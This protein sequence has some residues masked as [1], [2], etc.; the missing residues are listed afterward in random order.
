MKKVFFNRVC[1]LSGQRCRIVLVFLIQFFL[2]GSHFSQVSAQG[3][4]F[5]RNFM[6]DDYHAHSR[7]FDIAIG[8]DGTVYVA[9]FEGLMYYDKV[10]WHMLHTPGITRV[11]VVYRDHNNVIWA[12]GYNYFG[13]IGKKENGELYLQR[14]G[15]QDLFQGEVLEIWEKGNLLHFIVNNGQEYAV[16]GKKIVTSKKVHKNLLKAGLSDIVD[17]ESVGKDNV[18]LLTNITQT[19]KLGSGLQAVVKKGQGL[20]M[21]DEAGK[22]LYVITKSNGLCNDNITYVAYDNHGTLWGVTDEGLFSLA[23]PSA[24]SRFGIN[25]GLE[26]EIISIESFQQSMYVGTNAGLF[27]QKGRA[28]E[29]VGGINHACWQLLKTSKGLLA[30][31]AN[32]IYLL[33]VGNVRQISSES[34]T[35]VLEIGNGKVY[36]GEMDGLKLVDIETG[37]S[38]KV[39]DLEKV[40]KI[41][42]DEKG[43]VWLE[44]LYGEVWRKSPSDDKFKAYRIGI[45]EESA[46]TLVPIGGNV[47]A[48]KV[49]AESPF[50]YPRFSYKDDAG[51]TWLTDGNGKSIYRWKDQKRLEDFDQLLF[52]FKDMTIQAVYCRQNEIWFGGDKGLYV[53]DSSQ[54]DPAFET[55]PNLRFRTVQLNGD[56]LLWGGHGEMPKVL[57]KLASDERNL[58]FT[59]ALDYVP[60]V[61]KTLYRYRL[62]NENWSV[63]VDDNDAEFLNLHSG[64]YKISIQALLAS[65]KMTEVTTMEFSIAYPFYMKW[66]MWVIYVLLAVLFVYMLLRWRLYRLEKEKL[67]LEKV[68]QERTAEVVKQKD[69]IE[70]KSN[71][72]EKALSE[73]HEAQGE[74]IRQEKMATVGKLTQGLIDRILNPLNYINNFSKLSEGLVKDVEA[75][76]EDDKD[77]MDAENYEDT[78]DVL[79]MLSGNLQKV[80][81]HGQSTTRTLK[82]MEEMLKDRSGGIVPMNLISVLHQNEE[83]LRT[84]Y[85][86]DITRNGIK[87]NFEYPGE[88][89]NVNGNAEQLSKAFMSMLGN[90]VYAIVKKLQRMAFEPEISVKT[91]VQHNQVTIVIRDNGIGIEDTIINK[92]FDPFFTTK[93]TGEASG[94]GLYLSREIFQNHGGDI[95]V[96]SVK[97]E[98]SEFTMT[99]PVI[100]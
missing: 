47:E 90:S 2:L 87:V 95:R 92:V 72:L 77:N 71:S 79:G 57:P 31:T 50:P 8:E 94:V 42:K 26:G 78:K 15:R 28:F 37:G 88:E 16:D 80:S 30:A 99:L 89:L 73:L 55:K 61:G 91:S 96:N 1:Y 32:G 18:N 56:S 64:S 45:N 29:K 19:E 85:A 58:R 69:E 52:P 81:E 54:K 97:N 10:E 84:Y 22:E 23:V 34:S 59:Y 46:S 41:M 49:D 82:A 13:R 4:P 62:N 38:Q 14:V 39:C 63:W 33:S 74:L 36:S 9:N 40:V 100:K 21:T 3:I 7:N 83:M 53:I 68:I 44:S 6:S 25:E 75:N 27:R 24:F 70:E 98:Y 35:A 67:R 17:T 93:P 11:T 43:T 20:T 60:L 76:I 65:G 5:L 48:V 86:D 51:V 12:G 66:Y